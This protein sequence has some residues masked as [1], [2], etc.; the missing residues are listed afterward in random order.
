MFK[1]PG[2]LLLKRPVNG[3]LVIIGDV[4]GEKNCC[5]KG[6]AEASIESLS[7]LNVSRENVIPPWPCG[8]APVWVVLSREYSWKDQSRDPARSACPRYC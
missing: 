6:P 8:V 4:D 3:A 2:T 7:R 1:V 5:W